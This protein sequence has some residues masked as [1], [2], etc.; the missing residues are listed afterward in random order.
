MP[1]AGTPAAICACAR[2]APTHTQAD[3]HP[4]PAHGRIHNAE[5]DRGFVVEITAKNTSCC[6]DAVLAGNS[7]RQQRNLMPTAAENYI[8]TQKN[9]RESLMPSHEILPT[10][11]YYTTK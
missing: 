6:E 7:C 1:A 4:S 5:G 11:T 9:S 10:G 2:P 8:F 3:G